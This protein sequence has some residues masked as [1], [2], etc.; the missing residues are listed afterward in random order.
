LAPKHLQFRAGKAVLLARLE[1]Y[2]S[3]FRMVDELLTSSS[4][5]R[6]RYMAA[7]VYSLASRKDPKHRAEAIRLLTTARGGFRANDLKTDPDIDPIRDDPEVQKLIEPGEKTET[8]P[9]S[10]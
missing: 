5:P 2:E 10:K 6:M 8:S 9:G 4:E 3:A 7:C 1:Q